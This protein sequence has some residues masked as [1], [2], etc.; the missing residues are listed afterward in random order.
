MNSAAICILVFVV[1]V[2]GRAL[3]FTKDLKTEFLNEAKA[4]SLTSNPADLVKTALQL[5]RRRRSIDRNDDGSIA[6]KSVNQIDKRSLVPETHPENDED[7]H[8]IDKREIPNDV[9]E[10]SDTD[11]MDSG[12][13]SETEL[14]D[15]PEENR[16]QLQ[17]RRRNLDENVGPNSVFHVFSTQNQ[18]Y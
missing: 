17:R 9:E 3:G 6:D 14:S 10:E 15:E 5:M 8:L 13:D 7:V 4:R 1:F 2:H 16:D 11:T 12:G 18:R